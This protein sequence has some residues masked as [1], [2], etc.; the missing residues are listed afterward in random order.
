MPACFRER[1]RDARSPEAARSPRERCARGR[2]L[3]RSARRRPE[4]CRPHGAYG[5]VAARSADGVKVRRAGPLRSGHCRRE[6]RNHED[7]H[8]RLTNPRHVVSP[9]DE[10]TFAARA[11]RSGTG[12]T[13]DIDRSPDAMRRTSRTP[14][15]FRTDAPTGLPGRDRKPKS[16]NSFDV[17][18]HVLPIGAQSSVTG[19]A[20]PAGGLVL[21]TGRLTAIHESGH[22]AF[23]SRCGR[24]AGDIAESASCARA[25]VRS[26]FQP[27]PARSSAASCRRTPP[28]QARSSTERRARGWTDSRSC[29][30]ADT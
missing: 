3:A 28:A 26:L 18:T 1:R 4:P 2:T 6:H 14:R 11:S 27:S 15:T 13:H 21:S 8:E 9:S 10:C 24:R 5:T 23:S 16:R 19:G 20:T 25:L 30:R 22:S 7:A 12:M 29:C 17:A